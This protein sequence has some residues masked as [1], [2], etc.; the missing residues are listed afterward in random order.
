MTYCCSISAS[1]P[2]ERK[3]L[4]VSV[5]ANK[6][7][8]RRFFDDVLTRRKERSVDELIAPDAVVCIP[9]GRFTGPEGV[10]LASVQIASAFPDRRIE[11]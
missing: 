1:T 10:K 2:Y 8:A 4:F 7:I 6:R 3:R 11:V 5:T 9:T